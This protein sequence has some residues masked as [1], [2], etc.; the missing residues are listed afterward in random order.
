MQVPNVNGDEVISSDGSDVT[1]MDSFLAV[2]A[3]AMKHHITGVA[4]QDLIDLI[5]L[6]LPTLSHSP[7]TYSAI[8]SIAIK[9][10]ASFIFT[11]TA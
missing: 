4:L 8:C 10:Y 5:N 2:L 1:K 6:L 7:S 11:V 9:T 3:F